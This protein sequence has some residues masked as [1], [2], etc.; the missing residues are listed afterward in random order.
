[1]KF[2]KTYIILSIIISSI[3]FS[4]AKSNYNLSELQKNIIFQNGTER[5]FDNEYWDNKQDGIYIDIIDSKALFSS[6][7]KFDSG[8]GWPSFTGPI[9]TEAIKEKLDNSHSMIRTEVRAKDSDIHLGHVFND[10]PK[11]KGGM[12]YCINST[13]LKFIPKEDM[14]K[15]GY[16]KYLSSFEDKNSTQYQ[17]AIIAGGCFWGMEEL[18][19]K[20]D[21]VVDVVNGYTGGKTVNPTYEI[22]STGMSNH[23]EAVEIIFDPKKTSYDKILRFFFKIHDPTAL[24]KQGNDIGTQYRSAIFYLNEE[25]KKVADELINSANKSGVFP[26]RIVT[27]LEKFDIF[28]KAEEYHQ[29]YLKKNPKGYTCH[30][31]REDWIF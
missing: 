19:S 6:K 16:E 9:D 24:N 5:A 15:E 1:M 17:K 13:S 20:L 31:V 4:M 12:R 18:F 30:R 23:A 2:V 26:G 11:N 7:D 8:T 21:G 3:N 27:M 28:Y 29:D 25:Q 22:I 14:K 10:G